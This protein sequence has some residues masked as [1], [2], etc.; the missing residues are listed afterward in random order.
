LKIAIII[1]ALAS[2]VWQLIG[3]FTGKVKTP[4]IS[5]IIWFTIGVA[6]FGVNYGFNGWDF[7]SVMT[8]TLSAGNIAIIGYIFYKHPG[9]WTKRETILLIATFLIVGAWLPFRL[10]SE[11]KQLFWATA[12]SQVMLHC[13]HFIGVWNYWQKLWND[14]A[15]EISGPWACR[16]ALASITLYAMIQADQSWVAT[17]SP[18]YGA[19]TTGV[20]LWLIYSRRRALVSV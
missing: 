4:R 16:F 8:G 7:T 12:A 10:W 3:M 18:F 14:P 6:V 20:I 11:E 17:I 1:L 13:A 19:I 2:I 5:W 9:G 15:T